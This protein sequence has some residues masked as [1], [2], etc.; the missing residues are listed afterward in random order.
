MV[1]ADARTHAPDG[2]ITKDPAYKPPLLPA[3]APAA[4]PVSR[5]DATNDDPVEVAGDDV[6]PDEISDLASERVDRGTPATPTPPTTELAPT[7]PARAR[8][9]PFIRGAG[10]QMTRHSRPP[11]GEGLAPGLNHTNHPSPIH[12]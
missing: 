8:R 11:P 3:L 4:A 2:G 12:I 5:P 1:E 7:R 9:S 6:G 10:P